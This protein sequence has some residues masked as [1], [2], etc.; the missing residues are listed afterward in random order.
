M[1]GNV[2]GIHFIHL[3]AVFLEH[4]VSSVLA[5]H[6]RSALLSFCQQ[7]SHHIFFSFLNSNLLCLNCQK[8]NNAILSAYLLIIP[9]EGFSRKKKTMYDQ[10]AHLFIT[11]NGSWFAI[12]HRVSWVVLKCCRGIINDASECMKKQRF[13]L[14]RKI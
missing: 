2:Q 9:Y 4:F 8:S 5:N 3:V 12:R 10:I 14:G 11:P 13:E 7:D 6:P 1:I